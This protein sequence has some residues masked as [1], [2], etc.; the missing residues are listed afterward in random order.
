MAANL[1]PLGAVPL[2]GRLATWLLAQLAGRVRPYL[3][4]FLQDPGGSLGRIGD[5]LVWNGAQGSRSL[6]PASSPSARCRTPGSGW[7]ARARHR[8]VRRRGSVP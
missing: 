2:T 6:L 5:V 8:S 4:R 1:F 3:Q 7:S